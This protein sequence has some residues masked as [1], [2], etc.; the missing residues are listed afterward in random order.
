MFHIGMDMHKKF[1]KVEAIDE[2]GQAIDQRVLLHHDQERIR[3]YF[4]HVGQDGTVT[5]E[6]TRNWYWLFE[7][8][9]EE[10]LRV[11]LAHPSKVRL[12]AEARIK[13]DSIDASTLAHLE[14][15]GY[16]PE[17]YIASRDVRDYRELLRYRFSLARI[18][19]S[20]EN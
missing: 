4:N 14:R 7:L 16:L 10:E 1:S 13:T 5:L 6:A 2:R 8:L 19:T 3:E 20:L 18:R 17:A 9:E 11:K 12:I 15:T